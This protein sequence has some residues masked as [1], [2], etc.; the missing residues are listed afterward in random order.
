M[1]YIV[2]DAEHSE[3]K[4]NLF[5]NSTTSYSNF[6]NKNG[7]VVWAN[8]NHVGYAA[9]DAE[10]N[11]WKAQLSINTGSNLSNFILSENI[12]AW[13]NL[14]GVHV[15][16]FNPFTHIIQSYSHVNGSTIF[17]NFLNKDGVV[18]WSNSNTAHALCFDVDAF[19]WAFHSYAHNSS[20]FT[21]FMLSDGTLNYEN[22]GTPFQFGYD[23]GSNSWQQ[24][25]L[26]TM[27]CNLKLFQ[28]D[29]ANV[30]SINC[31]SLGGNIYNYT[32]GDGHT[33]TERWAFKRYSNAG[34]YNVN[35]NVAN[36]ASNTNCTQTVQM[37]ELPE[38]NSH[39]DISIKH[40]ILDG[41]HTLFITSNKTIDKI[42]IR[43]L[44][45]ELL[46]SIE[47]NKSQK[48]EISYNP[49]FV[50]ILIVSVFVSTGQVIHQKVLTF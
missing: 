38:L 13:S 34:I 32:M 9:F 30:V 42:E 2:F 10:L 11:K 37:T 7:I 33:I 27:E 36:N 22:N 48:K 20:N 14:Y 4:Y 47:G 45:G 46:Q 6:D 50:G 29:T 35:L 8:G 39:A 28:H 1:N 23:I 41:S 19:F 12:L 40:S 16:I 5:L 44:V 24:N 3:W 21:N 17:S 18:A 49:R 15:S 26:T 43:N 31:L 25:Y